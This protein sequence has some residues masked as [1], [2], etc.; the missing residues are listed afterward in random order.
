[1]PESWHRRLGLVLEINLWAFLLDG[2]GIVFFVSGVILWKLT[3]LWY[4]LPAGGVPGIILC[5]QGVKIHGTQTHKL[6]SYRL[7]L[8]RNRREFRPA[9]FQP[10][11]RAPCGRVLVRR[12]LREL[13]RSGEMATLKTEFGAP[14]CQFAE[15]TIQINYIQ[16]EQDE[17]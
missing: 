4:L 2:L 16:D 11:L 15:D 3:G 14:C 12:V 8:A 17:S 1:M 13:G 10:Y 7:L 6:R 5:F 9:S